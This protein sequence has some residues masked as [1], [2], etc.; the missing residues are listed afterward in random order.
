MDSRPPDT[1]TGKRLRNVVV[2]WSGGKDCALALY[3]TLAQT[4][5]KVV[6]LLTTIT[7][8]YGRV[9]MHGVREVLLEEQAR[10]LG[11]PLFKVS[12]P[13][14]CSNSEYEEKMSEMLSHLRGR[15]VESVVFG[16]IFLEDV[17]A[18]REKNLASVGMRGAL[19]LWGINSQQVADNFIRLGFKA[20]VVCV[21]T[22]VLNA[23]FAG[24]EFNEEFLRMLPADVDPCGENGEFHTFVYDGPIFRWSVGFKR[25]RMVL[26]E[27]RFCFCDL[28]PCG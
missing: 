3:L 22:E 26:R 23:T 15:G 27:E 6:G 18:F 9:S 8:D 14:D 13:A 1:N 16:D 28:L 24:R 20:V 21:D 11:L 5:L 12:I 17:R 19:P 7:E 2:A 4:R 25:G 10:A